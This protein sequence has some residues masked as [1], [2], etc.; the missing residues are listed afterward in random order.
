MDALERIV[1]AAHVQRDALVGDRVASG[2]AAALVAPGSAAEVAE[3]VAWCY[4]HDVPIV[5][6]GGR[7]G[8]WRAA[9]RRC[10]PTRSRCR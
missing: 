5:P 3:V 7:N 2:R 4:A 1:G 8:A 9:R 10:R 6:V